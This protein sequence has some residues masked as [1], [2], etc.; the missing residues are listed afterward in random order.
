MLV[1][2]KR[3]A[4]RYRITGIAKFGT[5]SSFGGATMA[6]LTLPEAQRISKKRGELDEIDV[7]VASGANARDVTA[8]LRQSLPRDGRREDRG[9]RTHRTRPTTSRAGSGS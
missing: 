9:S 8:E 5:S 4:K 3:P 2:G 1:A 6:V 7:A